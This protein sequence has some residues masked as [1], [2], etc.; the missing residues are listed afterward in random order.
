LVPQVEKSQT[1]S[2]KRRDSQELR[3]GLRFFSFCA[4]YFQLD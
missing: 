2:K 3:N 1:L 4:V